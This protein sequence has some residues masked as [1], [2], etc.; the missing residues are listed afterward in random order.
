[1]NNALKTADETIVLSAL[2]YDEPIEQWERVAASSIASSRDRR[3]QRARYRMR[4]IRTHILLLSLAF[5]AGVVYLV[6]S[7]ASLV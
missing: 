3:V 1:M 5:V 7:G 6:L 2:D 4:L